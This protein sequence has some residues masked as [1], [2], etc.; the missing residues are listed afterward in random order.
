PVLFLLS[1]FRIE[2]PPEFLRRLN[3]AHIRGRVFV[4][5]RIPFLIYRRLRKYATD[6][7][8]PG[9]PGLAVLSPDTS[10]DFFPHHENTRAI[11]LHVEDGNPWPQRNQQGQL[12]SLCEFAL[13]THF[14]IS[15]DGL[16]N[17]L[18]GLGGDG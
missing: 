6:L 4:S 7:R 8:F 15:S 11:H 18:H 16:R 14:D 12:Q 9:M 5:Y 2:P 3:N 1:S 17:T 13:L 10:F